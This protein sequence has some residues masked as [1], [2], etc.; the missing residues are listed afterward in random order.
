[1][2]NLPVNIL[3]RFDFLKNSQ[4]SINPAE[5]FFFH[6]ILIKKGNNFSL[7]QDEETL[8]NKMVNSIHSDLENLKKQH[9]DCF[10]E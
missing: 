10:D 3:I 7:I 1:M 8:E 5:G 9:P 6:L 2:P 4:M